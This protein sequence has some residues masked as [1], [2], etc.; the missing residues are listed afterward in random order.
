MT[1]HTNVRLAQHLLKGMK[2]LGRIQWIK[3]PARVAAIVKLFQRSGLTLT[4]FADALKVN[5]STINNFI[6]GNDTN[7][8]PWSELIELL[9]STADDLFQEVFG[10]ELPD[11]QEDEGEE[12][13]EDEGSLLD[14]IQKLREVYKRIRWMD[15]P[16]LLQEI[17]DAWIQAQSEGTSFRSF[18]NELG[19][20]REV[21]ERYFGSL[22]DKKK[23]KKAKKV[24]EVKKIC[25]KP[26]AIKRE[27]SKPGIQIAFKEMDGKFKVDDDASLVGTIVVRVQRDSP[28]Y[29]EI[30]RH[31]VEGK[32]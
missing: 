10:P 3:H 13:E 21:L 18:S 11:L 4:E 9:K 2:E 19:V 20:H 29:V 5:H 27:V 26:P 6:K 23:V 25:K 22:D 15:H 28:S 14:R 17:Y 8:T 16:E 7:R 1:E 30:L 12:D 24:A 32:R 31:F